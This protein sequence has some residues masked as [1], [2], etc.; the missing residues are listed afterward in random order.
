MRVLTAHQAAA[1]IRDGATVSVSGCT[2][3]MVPEEIL[4][5]VE[6]RFVRMGAPRD[7]TLFFPIMA[8]KARAGVG[9]AGTGLNRFGH[10][11]L[12]R[13]LIGGS[14]GRSAESQLNHLVFSEAV[15]AYNLP[16]GT[17][18]QLLRCAAARQ[19][20]LL[21]TTGIG[22][23]VDP[24]EQGGRLNART[25]SDLAEVVSVKGRE[26]LF[27]PTIPVDV[28]LIRGTTADE[29]GNISLEDEAFSL[30]VLY[31]AMAAKNSGGVVVVQVQRLAEHGS[32]PPKAVR[33]PTGLVDAVVL[34]DPTQH[35]YLDENSPAITGR[36]RQPVSL[37]APE[38]NVRTI[39]SR[40]ALAEMEPGMVVNLGAGVGMY[41]LP[42]VAVALGRARELNFTLEQ[43]PWGGIPGAG[44]I[45]RNPDAYLDSP[46]VF[47]FYDG[48]GIDVA[49][50][51]YAQVDKA[52]DVNV[53]RFDSSMPG[54]GGF[55]NITQAARKLLYCGT[56][57][58][59]GLEVECGNGRLRIVREGK[60]KRFVDRVAHKTFSA[61]HASLDRQEVLYIT[62][63]CV[64][65]LEPD[66]PVLTEV[67]PGIDLERDLRAQVDFAVRISGTLKTM[68]AE[69]FRE[70]RPAE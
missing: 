29:R 30:G 66:G 39:V 37:A 22:T 38:L 7:L 2:Y 8:E 58:T 49:C 70:W 48:G 19:P 36:L 10:A 46:E 32:I 31:H 20:G 47:D 14:Y 53:S 45:A 54:A 4:A 35:D 60:I 21:T 12:V 34:D 67:A 33:I 9:G 28:A 17:L 5:A 41:D 55:I 42:M 27:Y 25:T 64:F 61:K 65:R 52:G 3:R 62:E 56:L 13:R 11:G 68:D 1:L 15:E 59:K 40:R 69:L 51:S 50:L 43:G 44:G 24:R 23:F 26:L 63:R 18:F 6:A 16:M 57:T